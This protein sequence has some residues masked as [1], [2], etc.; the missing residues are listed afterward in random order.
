M[1]NLIWRNGRLYRAVASFYHWR[2]KRV[3]YAVD[4]G[5]KCFLIPV[6]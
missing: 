3:L 4:Y 2:A 1:D 5:K 6:R